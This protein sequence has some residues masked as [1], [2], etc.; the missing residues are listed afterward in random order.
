MSAEGKN[1]N[2]KERA[3][4]ARLGPPLS[5]QMRAGAHTRR[6]LRSGQKA[7]L[8]TNWRIIVGT[9]ALGLIGSIAAHMLLPAQF[10]PFLIGAIAASCGWWIHTLMLE[11]G[12]LANL[13]QGLTAE[14]LTAAQLLGLHRKGWRTANH[15]RIEF[16]DVDHA[17]LG[18]AGFFALETKFRSDWTQADLPSIARQARLG[19]DRL[20]PRLGAKAEASAIVVMWGPKVDRI[21]PEPI[22][23]DG[24]TFC[25]GRLVAEHLLSLPIVRE[26]VEVETAFDRL[27][28]IVQSRDLREIADEGDFV[29]PLVHGVFDFLAISLAFFVT[30]VGLAFPAH[31]A[32]EGW[33]TVVASIATLVLASTVRRRARHPRLRYVATAIG[34]TSIG[35]GSLMVF[36]I[37]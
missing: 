36:A 30:T 17:A 20:R 25:R 37:A 16:G 11:I 3:P 13:R 18:P 31:F 10:A 6:L 27:E 32:P 8:A 26:R 35:L 9:V 1:V 7:W 22:E 33:W 23:V 29:R 4:S 14:E 21:F 19:A 5:S 24:V 34:T 12:G 15:V 2:L 28:S